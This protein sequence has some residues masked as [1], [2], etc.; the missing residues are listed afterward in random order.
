MNLVLSSA[1]LVRFREALEKGG[2]REVGGI[3]MGEHVEDNTFR[4]TDVTVQEHG[5]TF[6]TFV[7]LVEGIVG[8][9][10]SFFRATRHQYTRFNYIG[11]WHSHHSFDLVPSERDRATMVSIIGDPSVGARFVV[12]L[13]VRLGDGGL[14]EHAATV[15]TPSLCFPA[16]VTPE[17]IVP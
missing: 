6:A 14:L 17:V 1:T 9:L 8:P 4:I 11:E 12:L 5:G 2:T 10:R 16:R 7:R 13:L 15:F 3:L